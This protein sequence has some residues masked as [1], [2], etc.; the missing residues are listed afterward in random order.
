MHQAEETYK[1][2][3]LSVDD[4]KSITMKE[5]SQWLGSRIVVQPWLLHTLCTLRHIDYIKALL[6]EDK[7]WFSCASKQINELGPHF[8][9]PMQC[10]LS[11]AHNE[12]D[13]NKAYA[14]FKILLQKGANPNKTSEL[15][16]PVLIDLCC[17]IDYGFD[18]KMRYKLIKLFMR[19]KADSCTPFVPTTIAYSNI[20]NIIL[21]Y[22][23]E[24]TDRG[25]IDK[26]ILNI[27]KL[28][29]NPC[30]INVQ[31]NT[32]SPLLLAIYKG[33]P[34]V[35]R[36]LLEFGAEAGENE[37]TALHNRIDLSVDH[38]TK[39]SWKDIQK[40]I[41]VLVPYNRPVPK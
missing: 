23:L 6:Q 11:Q 14:I 34:K 28:V 7:P 2:E 15:N 36:F 29:A 16:M 22:L 31:F 21:C 38:H 1:K 27:V 9:T 12:E 10:V 5:F 39:Q 18:L 41:Q 33:Y 19:N 13:A 20:I 8:C 3:V 30:N 24:T 26:K 40:L 17:N 35:A 32:D 4:I 37:I 25:D